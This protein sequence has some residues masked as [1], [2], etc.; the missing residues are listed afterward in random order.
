MKTKFTKNY[1]FFLKK[2]LNF[3]YYISY[4]LILFILF[5]SFIRILIF[6]PTNSDVFKYGFKKSVIFDV[7]DL[8]KL[9][10]TVIDKQKKIKNKAK[11]FNNEK[12]WIF[13]GS[14]SEGSGCK[15][16]YSSS[17]P[18]EVTKINNNFTF[19][20]FAFGGAFTDNQINLLYQNINKYVPEI[21]MWANKFNAVRITGSADYR[22]KNILKY[23]FTNT[24]KT[25]FFIN[26]KTIDKTLK[27]N[28]L[29]YALFD[30]ILTRVIRILIRNEI[31][32][33][34]KVEP[35]D[36]D[37]KY[38]LENFKLNT[39]EAVE[40]SKKYGVK[41]FYIIS[42]FSRYDFDED[43]LGIKLYYDKIIEIEKLYYPYVKIIKSHLDIEK[44][45][46]NELFCDPVHQTLKMNILQ[47]EM[48]ND[49][50]RQF[51]K[52]IK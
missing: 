28:F 9:Q 10:I 36:T 26:I 42:L 38:A 24:K 48:I 22:N 19:K 17:W 31:I 20:N 21:I 46:K 18:I 13:G 23:D 30:K 29:S 4:L 47:A 2:I 49:Q 1:F 44:Y 52:I 33:I 40:L 35:S 5:E 15:G 50:L 39:I 37:I 11:I 32:K 12:V 3:F 34:H 6:F 27:S 51:S 43:V 7:V 8:S 25:K 45:N 16:S 14:T 41:E